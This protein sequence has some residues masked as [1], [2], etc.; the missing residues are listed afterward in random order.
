MVLA[1]IFFDI[2]LVIIVATLVAL[3]A[4]LLRQPPI[5]AYVITGLVIGPLTGI[6]PD[7]ELVLR[8]SEFG[9]AFLLFLVGLE[10]DMRKLKSIGLVSALTGLGQ[11]A[12]TAVAGFFLTV[13]MGFSNVEAVYLSLALAFSSTM[14]VVKLLS[15]KKELDTLHG[16]MLVGI[17]LIQDVVAIFAL[18]LANNVGSY[19]LDFVAV[20]LFK[21]SVLF[22]V[23][24]LAGRFVL[25]GLFKVIAKSQELLF[26]VSVSWCFGLAMFA[27][28]LGYSIAIG[29]FL[30][31]ISLASFKYSFEIISRVR[32]LRDFFATIFFV[33]LGMQITLASVR[34]VIIPGIAL[35]A[36]VLLL[37]PLVVML[38]MS[39]F[40]Y[41]RKVSFLSA[42]GIAQI[43]EFSLIL[44]ALGASL[45]HLSQ[46]V[47]VLTSVVALITITLTSYMITYNSQ[48][49]GFMSRF[50]GIF[51]R[52]SV[53]RQEV[54]HFPER[55][56]PRVVLCGQNRI[57]YSVYSKLKQMGTSFLVVD[58]N[59]EIIRE[60]VKE[61]I[62]CIYGDIGDVDIIERLNLEEIEMLISTV[63]DINA[64][65]L[66]IKK[67]K[68]CNRSVIII[69]TS[70]QVEDALRLY[71]EGADYVIMPHFLGGDHASVLIE[72]FRDLNTILRTRIQHIRELHRRKKLGHEHPS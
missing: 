61:R 70:D 72:S 27:G 66:V 37:N 34:E 64:N 11:V 43:S 3:A 8:L 29:A 65:S 23:A 46:K 5:L 62:P 63:P 39:F 26:L 71:Q 45:G 47:V 41:N 44:V 28:V 48:I 56:R 51:A 1:N 24:F 32:S 52:V 53:R 36:F 21:G 35:S 55:F 50:L 12:F 57:G 19:S 30:A 42:I 38:F 60:L 40:G 59:P 68:E 20:S 22:A 13:A 9:V 25:Q 49:Y 4:S 15:D 67:L 7:S 69:V 6:V 54:E 16:R 17:L 18:A 14:I 31:G 10:M 58:Y 33:S 2:G